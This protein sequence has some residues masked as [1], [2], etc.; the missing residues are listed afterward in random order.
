M[1]FA[2]PTLPL[3]LFLVFIANILVILIFLHFI[4]LGSAGIDGSIILNTSW[5]LKN[6]FTPYIDFLTAAPPIFILSCKFFSFF[7]ITWFNYGIYSLLVS[8]VFFN[9]FNFLLRL[10]G[11]NL[12]E[13]ITS[14]F[15]FLLLTVMQGHFLWYNNLTALFCTISVVL[16]FR[17]LQLSRLSSLLEFRTHFLFLSFSGVVSGL[18]LLCKINWIG[19]FWIILTA[20]QYVFLRRYKPAFKLFVIILI[21]LAT[22][23]LC[24]SF[25]GFSLLDIYYN[26]SDWSSRVA[27]LMWDNAFA[28]H[29]YLAVAPLLLISLLNLRTY[30]SDAFRVFKVYPSLAVPISLKPPFLSSLPSLYLWSILFIPLAFVGTLMAILTNNSLKIVDIAP[31]IAALQFLFI[32]SF[33]LSFPLFHFFRILKSEFFFLSCLPLLVFSLFTMCFRISRTYSFPPYYINVPLTSPNPNGV[34]A[35]TK[36]ISDEVI[37]MA[38]IR[39]FFNSSSFSADRDLKVFFG[40]R[41][42]Y[43]YSDLSIVPPRHLPLW[44]EAYS[45]DHTLSDKKYFPLASFQDDPPHYIVLWDTTFLPSR[46]VSWIK[47]N[48]LSQTVQELTFFTRS[49]LR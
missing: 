4:P 7:P 1:S 41:I 14:S 35:G 20:A 27:S 26:Y 30:F 28:K 32:P 33:K 21:P 40:P 49:D 6:G 5:M 39:K 36:L 13:A 3:D 23:Y 8:I 42:D 44:W 45:L 29:I 15:V 12:Y 37:K 31:L 46:L 25:L 19:A 48:Y 34:F 47:S 10:I 16:A 24:T 22:V 11:F 38:V 9:A 43:M 17:L 18:L 2:K